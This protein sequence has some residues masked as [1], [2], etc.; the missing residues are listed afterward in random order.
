VTAEEILEEFVAYSEA[1]DRGQGSPY[2]PWDWWV[3]NVLL[4]REIKKAYHSDRDCG[5]A[6]Q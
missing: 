6:Q 1:N 3:A 4:P 5:C 2:I